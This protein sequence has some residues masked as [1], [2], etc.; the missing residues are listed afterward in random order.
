MKICVFGLWHLGCVTAACLA[1]RFP[2]V[3]VDLDPKTIAGLG[4]AKPPVAEPDLEGL[5]GA[6]LSSGM[7]RFT[8]DLGQAAAECDLL[9]ITFDTPVDDADEADTAFVEG[10]IASTFPY[11]RRGSL[12]LI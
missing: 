1:E 6:G 12:V 3:A 2:T 11:L 9:C 7:L 5:I 4:A 8:S 10:Q